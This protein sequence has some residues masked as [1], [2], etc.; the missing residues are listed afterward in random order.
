MA[1]IWRLLGC[2]HHLCSL[3]M[4]VNVAVFWLTVMDSLSIPPERREIC[5][6]LMLV[7]MRIPQMFLVE[8]AVLMT[9]VSM[10]CV[11]CCALV[12]SNA[13]LA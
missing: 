10:I 2:A 12:D 13:P 5:L 7:S 4:C 1:M 8:V 11:F 3:G 9:T 6:P